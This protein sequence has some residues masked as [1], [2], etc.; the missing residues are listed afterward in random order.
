[1]GIDV[2]LET[3]RAESLEEVLD[4][5]NHLAWFLSLSDEES[6]SC[7]AFIDP[8]GNTVFNG[9]QLPVLLS[10]LDRALSRLTEGRL[11]LAKQRYLADAELWPET[12]REQ[13]RVICERLTLT[14][15]REHCDQVVAV[16][17][18]ALGRGPHHY[19]RFVGD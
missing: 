19:V 15:V 16:V 18:S 2:R 7:L 4:Q 9:L 5:R 14:D 17:R 3:E 10:E 13:A 12:A 1:M 11:D 8:Y 6:T